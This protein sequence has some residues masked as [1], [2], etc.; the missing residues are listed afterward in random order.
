MTSRG[1]V[2]STI[3]TRAGDWLNDVPVLD[4]VDRRNAPLMQVLLICVGLVLPLDKVMLFSQSSFRHGLSSP[5]MIVDMAT[6][7][8]VLIAAWTS[9]FFIRRG[10]FRL[11]VQLYLGVMLAA[12]LLAYT[13]I[14]MKRLYADPFPLLLLGLAG[15]MLGRRSLWTVYAVLMFMLTMGAV[16]DVIY[17]QRQGVQW[18]WNFKPALA[19][20]YLVVAVV[21][22]RTI[23][24]LRETLAVSDARGLQLER[25]NQ[26]LEH[27]MAERERT[28]EH[29]IHAQKMEVVGRVASGVAHDFDNVL[30]VILGY[31]SRRERLADSGVGPLVDALEG[32]ELAA[33]RAAM[34]SR[35]LLNFS[36]YDTYNE[37]LADLGTLIAG[38]RPMLGQLFAPNIRTRI[39]LP[40]GP[41]PILIDRAQL[42]LMI[43]SIASN[44]GDAMPDGGEFRVSAEILDDGRTTL[45]LADTGVGMPPD[46]LNHI[47]EPFYT[48]KPIGSGTGLGLSVVR[49][50][51]L[52]AGGDVGV[53][54]REGAGARF[55]LHFPASAQ[56]PLVPANR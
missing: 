38:L 16:S 34:I 19:V 36:R 1:V 6:D 42:E 35:Q 12:G 9:L 37:E 32:V 28:T 23:G 48:T 49:E 18:E 56:S 55:M 54:S 30:G 40:D 11:G 10:G 22:D 33:E 27:E 26:R 53:S 50:V 51:M 8:M 52:R 25:T 24:A 13:V 47:F 46:T 15:L 2:A 44:A 4:P 20:S 7:V 41:L 14:G 45:T 21:L 17:D 31:A 29:L 3:W 43:L 39:Q 5:A